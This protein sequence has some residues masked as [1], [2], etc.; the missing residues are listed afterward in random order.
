MAYILSFLVVVH[1]LRF[2]GNKVSSKVLIAIGYLGYILENENF[3]IVTS[4][5]HFLIYFASHISS[6]PPKNTNNFGHIPEH[7]WP[8]S[9]NIPNQL[10][11][12]EAAMPI[13]MLK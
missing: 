3:N 7:I 9:F 6:C 12:R 8:F 4:K 10:T 5:L 11:N 2:L 13:N 1:R